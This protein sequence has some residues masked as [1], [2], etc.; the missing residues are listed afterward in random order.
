M[1]YYNY[2]FIVIGNG[3]A[4]TYASLKAAEYGSVLLIGKSVFTETSSHHAQGG[5]AAALHPDD[6]T[7]HHFS[8]TINTGRGLC[9]EEAV[10]TL[11]K[12]GIPRIEEL[13][14]NAKRAAEPEESLHIRVSA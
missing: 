14:E 2:D 8:D 13:I 11:V 10:L 12:E 4:G 7:N 3:L 6:N 5:I 9:D 1:S